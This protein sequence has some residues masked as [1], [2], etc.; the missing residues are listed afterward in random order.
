V[1]QRHVA[2][3]A[4]ICAV[5]VRALD[6]SG[7]GISVM[8]SGGHRGTVCA[9]DD[10]AATI[11]ELQF[12]LGEGPCYDAF[13]RG[14]VMIADLSDETHLARSPW[15]EFTREAAL[16]GACALF[17][18]PIQIGAIRIGAF[19]LYRDSPGPLTDRQLGAALTFADAAAGAMLADRFGHSI[20]APL[21]PAQPGASDH[22]EVHQAS[23]ILTV[24][25][26]I[27]IDDAFVRLRAHAFAT[28][29]TVND[30][31]RDIVDGRLRLDTEDR[32]QQ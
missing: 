27:T 17:A 21:D 23:G 11:E 25:L 13:H 2:T 31:A 20:D 24:Q 3:P 30:V 5:A 4:E 8:T 10:V 15:P 26:G 1:T 19:D 29:R 18:L 6:L 14:P 16:A 7:G 12:T 28:E 9:T 32:G 22:A